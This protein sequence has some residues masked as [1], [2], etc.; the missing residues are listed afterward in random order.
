MTRQRPLFF[1]QIVESTRIIFDS[2]LSTPKLI[3]Q[4]GAIFDGN[5]AMQPEEVSD[6]RKSIKLR[7]EEHIPARADY[8]GPSP[9][10]RMNEQP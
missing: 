5:C 7:K 8:R 4:E 2:R 9:Q 6:S 10:E 1:D 3:V